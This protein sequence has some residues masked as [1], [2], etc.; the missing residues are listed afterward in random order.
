[1]QLQEQHIDEFINL[2]RNRYGIE[3]D[4]ATALEKG[5]KLCRF[6]E[7]VMSEP[8]NETEYERNKA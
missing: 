3:L 2:Y 6:V 8:K 5:I 1:M 7:L 4:R